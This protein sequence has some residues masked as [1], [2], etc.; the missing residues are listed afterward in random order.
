MSDLISLGYWFLYRVRVVIV[1]ILLDRCE[2]E[3]VRRVSVVFIMI[4][5]VIVFVSGIG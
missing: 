3:R 1:S 4:I 5:I 2:D